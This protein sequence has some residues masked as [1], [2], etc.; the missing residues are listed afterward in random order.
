[1]IFLDPKANAKLLPKFQNALP[2]S[3]AAFP[4]QIS[5]LCPTAVEIL[6]VLSSDIYKIT[7]TT[8]QSISCFTFSPPY[9]TRRTSLGT[10]GAKQVSLLLFPRNRC[11][12]PLPHSVSLLP[13]S[14]FHEWL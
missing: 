1:V 9:F 8:K 11:S 3:H 12:A 2:F 4:M 6:L 10:F 14:S 7:T 13:S 5:K